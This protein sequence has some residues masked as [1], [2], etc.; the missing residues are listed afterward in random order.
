[1]LKI[2]LKLALRNIFRNKLYTSINIIGLGVASAFCI[3]VYLYVKNEKSFD[4]FHSE[5]DRMFRVEQTDVFS[6][7]RREKP[8]KSF[9]SFLMKNEEQKNMIETP[10]VF[11]GDLKTNF[12]EVENAVRIKT[13][14][15]PIVRIGNQS[16]KEKS[17]SSAYADADFFK[18]FNFPLIYGSAATVLS[19]HSE[20]VISERLAKKYFGSENPV[21]KVLNITSDKLLL[22]ISGVA[23]DF[24]ANSSFKFDIIVPRKADPEYAEE[25]KQGTNGFSDLL[26]IKL[27][28]GTNEFNFQKK[29]DIFSKGYF[30]SLT[31]SMAKDNPKD[32]P[33]SFHVY[34]RPFAE[35]HYNQSEGWN[36][37]TDLKNIYQLVCLAFIILLIASLNYI[38]LTLTSAASR[39]QDVGVRKTIGAGRMQIILQYYTETQL[40]AFIAVIA[41]FLLAVTCLPFFSSLTG[42]DIQLAQFSF[43]EI[44]LSLFVLAMLLGIIAGI[45]PALAMSGLKPLNIMRSFSA[46]RLNPVLSKCLVVVQFAICVILI[47]SSM[48]VNKQ[49]HYISQTSMGFDKD[50]LV[51]IQNP[52]SYDDKQSTKSLKER[53]YSFVASAPYLD[54]MTTASFD[55]GGYNEN[56]HL[57]N[58]TRVP[59]QELNVDYDYFSF[60]KI[61]ILKGRTFSRVIASDT[62]K[63]IIT[64]EQTI[65]KNSEARHNVVINETLYNMLGKPE[66][67]AFNRE[68]GGVIIGVCKD[69]HTDDLTKKIMPAY[70]KINPNYTGYYW[71]RIKAG[72]N[73]PTAMENIKTNWNRLTGN[74]PFSYTFMDED[75]AKRYDAYLRWMA[76]ITTSCFLAIL[77]ACLGLFGLSGLTT[78]NRTKEIGI[79]KVLGA[80]VSNLFMLLNRGTLILAL[81]SFIIAAPIAFYLVHQ[82]LDNFA[83]RVE[84][85]WALFLAA[86]LIAMATA[87]I[88]VSYHTIKAAV[89]NPVN[90]L[91][92]E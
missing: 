12:P 48:V 85:D 26:I 36:H 63:L 44:A 38:L 7:F 57:I 9:F 13:I 89:A 30:K 62:A 49:M 34:L 3:L 23:K 28:K 35:A 25:M 86:G 40:L 61:P 11:A 24:P 42:A 53:L 22:T 29:L 71:I 79:R 17:E 91:R 67:G 2:N 18:V 41:G 20:V 83:Y 69:Y 51:L 1:M 27:Q 45:Y 55:F 84:P 43:S 58:G 92:S 82:W 31:E 5:Q 46:F 81:G 64:K 32:K 87:A 21:G 90:S 77:I 68:I 78:I 66:V 72:Q 33:Q 52:Y 37:Y 10:M 4:S 16:F 88:A 8:Q 19:G 54:G 76:T 60:N 74:Q 65:A 39:S 73:I 56:G 6:S 75:V 47:I 59:L 80:S 14:Y 15:N 50:Q 70:H